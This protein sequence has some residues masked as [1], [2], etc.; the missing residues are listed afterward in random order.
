MGGFLLSK[1]K[2]LFR[3]KGERMQLLPQISL[4]DFLCDDETGKQQ[5][6]TLTT[7][8]DKAST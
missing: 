2:P 3:R 7:E 1:K 4:N 6:S 8:Y 5:K